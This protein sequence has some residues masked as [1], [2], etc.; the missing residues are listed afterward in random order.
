MNIDERTEAFISL[1]KFFRDP[2]RE[3]V[4]FYAEEAYK[5]NPWFTEENVLFAFQSLGTMLNR[6]DL[7]TLIGRYSFPEKIQKTV[8]VIAAGNIPLAGFHDFASVLLSGHRLLLKPS[9]QDCFLMSAIAQKLC[10]IE[11]RF[12]ERIVFSEKLEMIDA[13]IASGSNNASRYFNYYFCDT[14]K[15]IRKSRTSVAILDGSESEDDLRMLGEDIFRY[16]GLGC[17]NV[18]KIYV[19]SAVK[20]NFAHLFT[21]AQQDFQDII[22][23]GKYRNNY[24]YRKAILRMNCA[25]YLDS[26]LALITENNS[27]ASPIAVLHSETYSSEADLSQKIS[28]WYEHIQCVVSRGGKYPGSTAFGTAQSPSF[29]DYADEIDTLKFLEIL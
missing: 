8:G 23:H 6:T 7:G 21:H 13:L 19:T 25:S 17:R 28:P 9:S 27:I 10:D 29:F 2:S 4:H 26:G 3:T 20:E 24:E 5:E 1:G 14:P 15:I 22:M 11:P 16:F 12:K 18:S